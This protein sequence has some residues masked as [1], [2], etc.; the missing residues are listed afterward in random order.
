MTTPDNLPPEIALKVLQE[1]DA[2]LL[3]WMG[4][5]SVTSVEEQKRCESNLIMAKNAYNQAEAMR[6]NLTA[7]MYEA[8][9]RINALF[10]PYTSRLE[11]GINMSIKTL[12]DWRTFSKKEAERKLDTLAVDY[13][14]KVKESKETGEVV[15]L[16]TLPD[17]NIAK[18]SH[19]GPGYVSYIDGFE[20]IIISEDKVPRDLCKADMSKIRARVKSGIHQIDG[21]SITQKYNLRSK[22]G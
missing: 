2:D 13:M 21:V 17:L 14:N 1:K 16:P 10:K 22:M 7:P 12:G 19:S 15:N 9:K 11:L 8:I 18:T 20:I 6:K 4:Q 5:I 3:K